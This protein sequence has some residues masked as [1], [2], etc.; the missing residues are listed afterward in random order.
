MRRPSAPSFVV[1]AYLANELPEPERDR[2]RE[3]LLD[4]VRHGSELLV[5]EPLSGRAAP[6][7][8]AWVDAFGA[9]GAQADTWTLTLTP[10]DL[11]RR[12]G[13]AAGLTPGLA[14]V[15]TIHA[16]RRDPVN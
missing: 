4:A 13:K 16:G 10:P 9:A 3:G 1:A 14:K 8:P 15:R 11:T 7:W 2:L 6:W 5:I 12:L